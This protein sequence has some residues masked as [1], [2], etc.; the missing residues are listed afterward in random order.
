MTPAVVPSRTSAVARTIVHIGFTF[1]L[2]VV[3]WKVPSRDLM[4]TVTSTWCTQRYV[5]TA[6]EKEGQPARC[7]AGAG[8]GT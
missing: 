2:G 6:E 3:W 1:K 8:R 5:G 4:S 7:S